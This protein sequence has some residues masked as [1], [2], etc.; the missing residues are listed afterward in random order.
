M[1]LVARIQRTA[2]QVVPSLKQPFELSAR[3]K[4]P[5]TTLT[6]FVCSSQFT[7]ASCRVQMSRSNKHSFGGWA[8]RQKQKR[9]QDSVNAHGSIPL[10]SITPLPPS[11]LHIYEDFVKKIK[12]MNRLRTTHLCNSSMSPGTKEAQSLC[13]LANHYQDTFSSV[14]KIPAFSSHFAA[15]S[16][17]WEEVVAAAATITFYRNR[18]GRRKTNMWLLAAL[19]PGI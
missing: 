15:Q 6:R 13:Q 12:A 7:A 8:T 1:N 5:P 16:F 11:F 3:L 9:H 4:F 17:E 10:Y 14:E 2:K 18:S 19:V